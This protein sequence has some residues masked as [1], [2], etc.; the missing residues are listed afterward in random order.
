MAAQQPAPGNEQGHG[1]GVTS[2]PATV[3]P[4]QEQQFTIPS[5]E[6]R[7][8]QTGFDAP[9]APAPAPAPAP[10]QPLI[11]PEGFS[12]IATAQAAPA[13]QFEARQVE[14]PDFERV[15]I[16]YSQFD[17]TT[18]DVGQQELVGTQLQGLLES[19]SPY[20]QQALL[21]GQRQAASR[22]AL[23]SS[24]AAG[25]SQAAA[26]QAAFPIAAA[27]AQTYSRVAS[28]NVAAINNTNLAKLQSTTQ[29]ATTI[30]NASA[31]MAQAQLSAQTQLESTAMQ[32]TSQQ[33]IAR[34]QTQMQADLAQ[35][36]IQAQQQSQV[37]MSHHDQLMEMQRQTGRIEL[38]NLDFGFRSALQ[39]RGFQHDFDMSALSHA[40][41]QEILALSNEYALDQIGFQGDINAFLQNQQVQAGFQTTALGGMLNILSSIGMSEADAAGQ[42]AAIR[43]AFSAINQILNLPF[44]SEFNPG[45]P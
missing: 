14:R 29:M 15:G 17:A 44:F 43:N 27:D 11:T 39:E 2:Q 34:M 24:L 38:A 13:Q 20:M 26:I 1:V 42:Q 31:A 22:G 23:S 6:W 7:T 32:A 12:P 21:A 10:T 40:Q 18:R 45:S 25:A 36:N 16:D 4:T 28:E 35:M 8:G 5:Y 9:S 30:M 3:A 33:S 37:F 41:Q 19:Q